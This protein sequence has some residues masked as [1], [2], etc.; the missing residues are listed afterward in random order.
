M[1]RTPRNQNSGQR[2]GRYREEEQTILEARINGGM[3]TSIDQADIENN[4]FAEL[5]NVT[6]R[7]D[8]TSRRFGSATFTPAAPDANKILLL[9]PFARFSGVVSLNRLTASSVYSGTSTLWNAVVGVLSGGTND[10]FSTA[11]AND[12]F[13]FANNGADYIQ[14]LNPTA[15]THARAGNAP[16]YRYITT[17]NNRIIGANLADAV[18]PNSVQIGWS[19]DLAFT[20]W[21]PLVDLSAGS[22]PLVDS[23]TG[24][25]DP[26][27][28]IFGFTETGLLLRERSLYGISKQPIATS[29]FNFFAI[30]PSIGCD[31]PYSAVSIRN[32]IAWFDLR[33]GSVYSYTIGTP[34]PQQIGFPV[35]KTIVDQV[36]NTATVFASYNTVHDEY[37]LCLPSETST[38]VR[39]WTYN[40]RT[41]AWSY[42]EQSN[43]SAL[44]NIDYNSSTLVIDDLVGTIDSLTG[45]IDALSN[46]IAIASRFYGKTNGVIT[47]EN[48]LEDDDAGMA[49]TTS[50]VSKTFQIPRRLGYVNRLRIEYT[51]RLAGAFTA[52]YSKDGGLTWNT[53]KTITWD[54]DDVGS[55]KLATFN[56]HLKCDQYTWKI[57]SA[58]GLFDLL[59]YEVH[60]ITG[61][62]D[63]RT[64]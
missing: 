52:Y 32:G 60:A 42:D 47:I 55:R 57:E 59:E 46:N 12:R 53:Y 43:I 7:Y 18:S 19:G 58:S 8:K 27:T 9:T 33:T 30:A 51:P 17:F 24:Y 25:A 6:V 10:R 44:S 34:E 54:S 45:M 35:E 64:R 28:G 16:K 56:K 22:T 15:L 3:V 21:D 13:F 49:Y 4:Q 29:P 39:M 5:K 36:A 14:E 23:P 2:A 63:S 61:A 48:V 41:K 26:I 20:E 11:I 38:L 40:F 37:T 31:C 62:A 50:I 1:L